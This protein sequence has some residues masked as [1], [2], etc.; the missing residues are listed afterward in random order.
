M[1]RVFFAL[2]LLISTSGIAAASPWARDPA[3]VFLSF[4][5]SAD[6]SQDDL[7]NGTF[8]GRVFQSLYG[9][10]GLGRRITLVFNLGRDTDTFLGTVFGQYTFTNSA[11]VWQ[12][13]TELGIGVID[14]DAQD[15]AELYRVGLSFGRGFQR[16]D[17]AWL[18]FIDPQSA[19]FAVDSNIQIDP[20]GDQTIWNTEATLGMFVTDR[21]GGLLQIQAEEFADDDLAVFVSPGVL[22]RFGRQTTALV[23]GRFGVEGSD[24]VG[25]RLS[26]WQDF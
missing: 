18:P 2:A 11:S 19:W 13:A 12:V 26:I 20:D 4:T 22:V 9:E 5:L 14:T 17:L 16:Q 10:V 1:L 21:F 25:V 24:D 8:D 23:G 7:A 3:D 15:A 6:T